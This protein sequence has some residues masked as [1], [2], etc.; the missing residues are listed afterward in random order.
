MATIQPFKGLRYNPSKIKNIAKVMAPPYDVMSPAEQKAFHQKHPNNVIHLDFGIEKKGDRKG[1]DKYSRAAAY[2][3]KWT[4]EGVLHEEPISAFYV[5]AHN[6]KTPAGVSKTFYG[7]YAALKVEEY[8]RKIVLPHEKTLS[9]PKNDRMNLTRATRANLSPI[10]FLWNDPSGAGLRWLKNE[11]K[12]RPDSRFKDHNGDLQRL[13]VVKSPAAIRRIQAML[14]KKK[15]YIADGHHRYETMLKYS[16]ANK[17]NRLAGYT[18]ACL[19]PIQSP[20]L[21]VL[22]TH[23]VLHSLKNYSAGKILEAASKWFDAKKVA[24]LP[25]LKKALALA[26]NKGPAYALFAKGQGGFTLLTLKKGVDLV[27]E[28][29]GTHSKVWRKLDV[30]VLQALIFEKGLKLT[31]ASIAAQENLKY[32]K[33]ATDAVK[34]VKGAGKF[35]AAFILN[36]TKIEEVRDISDVGDNM[37]Q[38]STYFLPKLVTGHVIRSMKG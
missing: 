9:K 23:R 21:V 32:V 2:L 7:L 15:V 25:A 35:Q 3:K 27:K 26:G 1:S 36:A 29:G 6:F 12:G 4:G 37:P 10:F 16:R 19:A 18:L 38:K 33:E 8:R 28:V 30:S 34:L 24:S 22:P 20:G 5:L 11:A 31:T 14:G 17:K 13:W